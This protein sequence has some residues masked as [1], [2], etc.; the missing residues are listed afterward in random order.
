MLWLDEYE[1]LFVDRY[2]RFYALTKFR[3]ACRSLVWF[4]GRFPV[5]GVKKSHWLWNYIARTSL[6]KMVGRYNDRA[7]TLTLE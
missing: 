5:V 3:S 2:T 1:P 7:R 6:A 4:L